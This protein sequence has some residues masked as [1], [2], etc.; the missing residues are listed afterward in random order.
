MITLAFAPAS[1]PAA[2]SVF[3]AAAWPNP[4]GSETTPGATESVI[5]TFAVI[6]P[7]RPVIRTSTPVAMPSLVA[8]RGCMSSPEREG[9]FTSECRLCI[10]ELLDL[11]FA[12][13]LHLFGHGRGREQSAKI[14][15]AANA[16]VVAAVVPD[17]EQPGDAGELDCGGRKHGPSRA[18][19]VARDDVERLDEPARH[20]AELVVTDT[21]ATVGHGA[22]SARE[23]PDERADRGRFDPDGVGDALGWKARREGAE[24]VSPARHLGDRLQVAEALG[25]DR[26][27]HG[28]EER[29]VPAGADE[30]VLVAELGSLGPTASEEAHA[31]RERR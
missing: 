12:R 31:R 17:V 26:V 9:P 29:R 15:E 2:R 13:G 21:D 11:P 3:A 14:G 22:R 19:E 18:V 6:D 1:A 24:L 10:H 28:K 16:G 30:V 8:S 20:R 4:C 5:A 23:I 27:N 7:V 25:E